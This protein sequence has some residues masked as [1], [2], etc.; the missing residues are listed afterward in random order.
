MI[1]KQTLADLEL[2]KVLDIVRL[3]SIS[4]KGERKLSSN[5]ITDDKKVIDQ[6]ADRIDQ[7]IALIK[8]KGQSV[9]YF[10]S[11][12]NIFTYKNS[13]SFDGKDIYSVGSFLS[14]IPSLEAFL[15]IPLIDKELK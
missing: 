3:N 15:D 9:N 7:I 14:S 1:N 2:D 5:S 11:I 13:A 6:R 4:K 10:C 8:I 12:D